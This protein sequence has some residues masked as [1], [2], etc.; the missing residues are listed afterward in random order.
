[1]PELVRGSH[2]STDE[3][4]HLVLV[5]RPPSAGVTRW[6]EVPPR[7]HVLHRVQRNRSVIGG[8]PGVRH[9][10]PIGMHDRR[11]KEGEPMGML[12]LRGFRIP[13]WCWRTH[14]PDSD[15]AEN[16]NSCESPRAQQ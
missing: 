1:M 4:L 5:R 2:R 14:C 10:P 9:S 12:P 16:R 15:G 6:H 7:T 8:C 11:V 13:V 3:C